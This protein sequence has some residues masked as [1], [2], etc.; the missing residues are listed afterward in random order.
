MIRRLGGLALATAL[1][2]FASSEAS[3]VTLNMNGNGLVAPN[4]NY[5]CPAGSADCLGSL[6]YQL[7]SAVP[8]TSGSIVLDASGTLA[9]FDVHLDS[10]TFAPTGGGANLV[11]TDVTYTGTA[12]VF[13][14][15]VIVSQLGPGSGTV[16]GLLNGNPFS[17]PSAIYNL[18]CAIAGISGQCGFAFGPQ[19]FT[20]GGQNW[21]HTFDVIVKPG[22]VPEP[23]TLVLVLL[24]AGALGLRR[25]IR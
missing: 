23:A 3:A 1:A 4:A 13:S 25:R 21:L 8:V 20:A 16:S 6:D 5:G 14:T 19:Q 2:L 12:A 18:T 15:P 17:T 22:G 11:F 7:L 24:G 10:A 9:T